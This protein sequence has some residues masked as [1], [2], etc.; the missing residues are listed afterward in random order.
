[1][2]VGPHEQ[3]LDVELFHLV[4]DDHFG[5]PGNLEARYVEASASELSFRRTQ[6][7]GERCP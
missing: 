1:M 3:Q 4:G 6:L 5:I 7:V 2:T